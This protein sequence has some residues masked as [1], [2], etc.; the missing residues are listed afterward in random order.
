MMLSSNYRKN[1]YSR[2]SKNYAATFRKS[3][4]RAGELWERE[5]GEDIDVRLLWPI[6][7]Y[8]MAIY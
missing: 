4:S 7:F 8:N 2:T 3:R 6:Q 1:Y 5:I